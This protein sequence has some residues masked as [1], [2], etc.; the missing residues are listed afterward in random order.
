MEKMSL[1]VGP[2]MGQPRC[3]EELGRRSKPKKEK[4]KRKKKASYAHRGR[5]RFYRPR[6]R[7]LGQGTALVKASQSVPARRV[8]GFVSV[9]ACMKGIMVATAAAVASKQTS[10]FEVRLVGILT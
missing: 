3:C 6:K 7:M 1:T 4:R 10:G 2:W 8:F 9:R 5:R